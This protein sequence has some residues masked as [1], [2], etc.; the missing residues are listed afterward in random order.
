MMRL[1]RG[2]VGKLLAATLVTLCL[3]VQ[4]LEV[5]GHWDRTFQDAGDEAVIVAVVLC[6]GAAIAVAHAT[7]LR[8]SLSPIGS[9]V[10]A[11]RWK[12]PLARPPIS[13]ALSD[14]PPLSLRL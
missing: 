9:P 4:A 6:I 3:G 7:R 1:V 13:C 12:M 14:S 8:V 10:A 11:A 5:T 2:T